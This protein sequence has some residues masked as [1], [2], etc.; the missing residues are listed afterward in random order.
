MIRS[1]VVMFELSQP[2]ADASLIAL[3]ES[4]LSTLS[5]KEAHEVFLRVREAADAG[6]PF[7][8]CACAQWRKA[9]GQSELSDIERY[10]WAARAASTGYPPGLCELAYLTENGLG[11]AK[12]PA[13]A[14]ELYESAVA[15]GYGFAAFQIGMAF[16]RGAL[17]NVDVPRAI[18]F[19]ERAC[20]LGEP[21]AALALGQ[22]FESGEMVGPDHVKAL[23]W[24]ERASALG[25]AAATFRLH[26]AYLFGEL[27]ASRD[28]AIARGYE[29]LFREQLEASPGG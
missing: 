5:E 9:G 22:W 28:A 29:T 13:R 4:R 21:R 16:S 1:P 26:Q 17:G 11:V 2:T 25:D 10:G 14:L 6:S 3:A 15:S 24:Y 23:S 18:R 27:G 12:N 8:M 20:E 7:A 19:M